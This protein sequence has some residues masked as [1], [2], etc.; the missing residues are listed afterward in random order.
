MRREQDE[1][2]ALGARIDARPDDGANGDRE[3]PLARLGEGGALDRG[4]GLGIEIDERIALDGG[5][6]V[7]GGRVGLAQDRVGGT[8]VLVGLD[9]LGARDHEW[10]AR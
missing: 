5:A 8:Q 4:K 2:H 10:G 6:E 3:G 1:G 7:D 9:A